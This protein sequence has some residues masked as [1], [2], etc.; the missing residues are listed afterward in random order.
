MCVAHRTGG[1][2]ERRSEVG[3]GHGCVAERAGTL[4]WA[5]NLSCMVH[6]IHTVDKECGEN[7]AIGEKR[8]PFCVA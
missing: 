2:A 3:W 5:L 7:L 4:H 1:D 6:M 8:L